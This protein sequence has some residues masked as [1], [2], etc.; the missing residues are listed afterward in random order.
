MPDDTLDTI[1][2]AYDGF[3]E[4][5]ISVI[6]D[7]LCEN[8]EFDASEALAH[9][10]VHHGH[11]GIA[12]YLATLDEVW[13]DLRIEAEEILSSV[14]GHAMVVGHMTGVERAS[15]DRVEAPF[16]HVLRVRSG[17][18]KRIQVYVDRDRAMREMRRQATLAGA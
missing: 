9:R 11:A 18:V 17:V 3:R 13:D 15:G 1:R 14:P 16:I 6:L 12:G 4:R 2:R 5:N 7:A 8:V 10:G